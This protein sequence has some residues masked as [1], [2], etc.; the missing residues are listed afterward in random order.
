MKNVLT[1]KGGRVLI[2]ILGSG[3]LLTLVLAA[4]A[5]ARPATQLTGP[6]PTQ[7][8][9]QGYLT[10]DSGVPISDTLTITF[11]LYAD[12]GGTTDLW[13]E[14]QDVDVINGYFSVLLGQQ[15]N[16]LQPA[17]FDG[18]KRYLGVQPEGA[19]EMTPRQPIVSVPYA[20]AATHAM[21]A[22]FALKTEGYAHV[23]V[24]AESGGDYTTINEAL[25]AI[26]DQ[27]GP[28][29][30][31]VAP[32]VYTESITVKSNVHLM[33]AGR[34]YTQIISDTECSVGLPPTTATVVMQEASRL[35]GLSVRNYNDTC[36]AAV[37]V[38]N[39]ESR[40][41]LDDLRLSSHNCTVYIRNSSGGPLIQNSK[42]VGHP[43]VGGSSTLFCLNNST[44]HLRALIGWTVHSVENA[45]GI[46][47]TN[48]SGADVRDVNL[49][50]NAKR[51]AYGVYNDNSNATLRNS[52][53]AS[54]AITRST[55]F[56]NEGV[57][58]TLNV[59]NMIATAQITESLGSSY[60]LNNTDGATASL[61]NSVLTARGG[62]V[63]MGIENYGGPW[64]SKLTAYDVAIVATDGALYTAGLYN[65]ASIATLHGGSVTAQGGEGTAVGIGNHVGAST[66]TVEGVIVNGGGAVQENYGVCNSYNAIA[67][68]HGG[69]FV[70]RGGNTAYGIYNDEQGTLIAQGSTVLAENALT[71]TVALSNGGS[72]FLGDS[73]AQVQGGTFT[74]R[75]GV[76]A[77]GVENATNATLELDGVTVLAEDASTDIRGIY[78]HTDRKTILRRG[79]FT[80]QGG[81]AAAYGAYVNNDVGATF[82]AD[83]CQFIGSGT[84]A[85][86]VIN[87]PVTLALSLVDG[88]ISHIG[89]TFSCFQ[90]YDE[91]YAAYVC[92]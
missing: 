3:L 12:A 58:A 56:H 65:R 78:S 54:V 84:A 23:I 52:N 80:G 81:I 34:R 4:V 53:F 37:L 69:S 24:V 14:S 17:H 16:P 35:S 39:G 32:G 91:N 62:Q 50:I 68:L 76:Y 70:A 21:T 10:D 2:A 46:S 41:L 85:L 92:P 49:S 13:R 7:I 51:Y 57:S 90:V 6:V 44:P 64:P 31:W 8:N 47:L 27:E 73:A 42:I 20:L 66:L 72:E 71:T 36:G 82:I 22:S 55:V 40:T 86:R 83:S 61:Y 87:S 28:Y 89:G 43:G 48:G 1:A 15:G 9:Y 63:A 5:L 74:A 25:A 75:D 11:T 33:G 88:G 59:Y 29:L 67:T 19:P 38:N 30:V 79:T 26:P 45:Y 77:Y 18:S 60:G